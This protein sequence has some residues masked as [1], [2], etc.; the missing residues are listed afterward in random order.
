[1]KFQTDVGFVPDFGS[2]IK[3]LKN[4]Y[5]LG[6][7]AVAI[8]THKS[9][10]SA[11]DNAYMHVPYT[12]Q[13]GEARLREFKFEQIS[14][15]V[16][17]SDAD[18]DILRNEFLKLLFRTVLVALYEG[19]KSDKHRFRIVKSEAWFVILWHM[20]SAFSHGIGARWEI[21]EDCV[22]ATWGRPSDGFVIELRREYD[23]QPMKMEQVGDFLT[24]FDMIELVEA[25]EEEIGERSVGFRIEDEDLED[26][27]TVRD[28]VD[29]VV[30]RL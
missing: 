16:R 24:L 19:L 6:L 4:S 30:A 29:Y 27:K 10:L 18:A 20:R 9:G 5:L 15:M 21:K 2:Q 12:S 8:T 22:G 3:N 1:M 7:S 14:K 23:G 11:L 25:L 17:K 13:T 26:L 28:A